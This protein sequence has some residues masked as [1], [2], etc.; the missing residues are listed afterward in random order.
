MA[1]TPKQQRFVEAYL[2]SGNAS[3]AAREAGYKWPDRQGWQQLEKTSIQT[4]LAERRA[5]L[6]SANDVT[7]EQVIEQWRRVAFFD[8]APLATLA[9]QTMPLTPL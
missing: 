7:V 2:V 9:G 5:Q 4:A 6:A 1:L 3:E 8:P